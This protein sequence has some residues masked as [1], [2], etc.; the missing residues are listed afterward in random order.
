MINYWTRCIDDI[1]IGQ[2]L[3]KK[4]KLTQCTGDTK[5]TVEKGN[6][7]IN[8]LDLIV[9]MKSHKIYHKIYRKS[10]HTDTIIPNGLFSPCKA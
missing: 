3:V 1:L 4:K 8:Y 6:K 7:I 10:T 2:G 5:F 9:T